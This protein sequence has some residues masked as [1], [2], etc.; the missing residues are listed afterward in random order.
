M[1]R[2]HEHKQLQPTHTLSLRKL[3]P[4]RTAPRQRRTSYGDKH[5]TR[6]LRR[7]TRGYRRRTRGYRRAARGYRRPNRR[8]TIGRKKVPFI[9]II[10]VNRGRGLGRLL[11]YIYRGINLGGDG[12]CGATGVGEVLVGNVKKRGKRRC[13]DA[14]DVAAACCDGGLGGLGEFEFVARDPGVGVYT[15]LG[16]AVDAVVEERIGGLISRASRKAPDDVA[17]LVRPEALP[18]RRNVVPETLEGDEVGHD[19]CDQGRGHARAGFCGQVVVCFVGRCSDV[20]ARG[21]DEYVGT[22][23]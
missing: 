18:D 17:K 19:A 3:T 6:G 2:S 10:S 7:P 8:L 13:C 4:T 14:D 16:R 20:A 23:V 21:D 9:A 12:S 5:P 15:P 11:I 22:V 1:L